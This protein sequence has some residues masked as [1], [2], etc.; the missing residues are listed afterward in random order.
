MVNGNSLI[1]C[2]P[3]T[4]TFEFIKA[5]IQL[6]IANCNDKNINEMLINILLDDD[7][8]ETRIFKELFDLF[9]E[10]VVENEIITLIKNTICSKKSLLSKIKNKVDSLNSN[11]SENVGEIQKNLIVE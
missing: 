8:D 10:I 7:L 1:L 11:K 3:N 2:Q 6:R 5:L 4:R 9:E